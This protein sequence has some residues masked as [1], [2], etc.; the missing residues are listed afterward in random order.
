MPQ[1]WAMDAWSAIV[2]DGAG[3]SDVALEIAVLA[4]YA[5]AFLVAGSWALQRKLTH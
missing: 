1:A 5:L 4:G 2:N 3:L